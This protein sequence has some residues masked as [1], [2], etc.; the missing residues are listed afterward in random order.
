ME[1]MGNEKNVIRSGDTLTPKLIE[2]SV[3]ADVS[4]SRKVASA[5]EHFEALVAVVIFVLPTCQNLHVAG[6]GACLLGCAVSRREALSYARGRPC[7]WS[8]RFVP[9]QCSKGG[10]CI[11]LA[12]LR[13]ALSA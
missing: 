1:E 9:S 7:S 11:V 12:P 8:I 13:P 5:M 6:Q 2:A 10:L 3:N 4:W